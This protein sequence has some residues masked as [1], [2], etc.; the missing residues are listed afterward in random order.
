MG[1]EGDVG[2]AAEDKPGAVG[3]FLD[4]QSG[5][6][7]TVNGPTFGRTILSPGVEREDWGSGVGLG[8]KTILGSGGFEFVR[9]DGE[10]W[11]QR[12]GF[13]AKGGGEVEIGVDVMREAWSL[14]RET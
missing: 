5:F 13:C 12:L 2:G 11:R 9:S 6:D 1:G 8:G 10:E 7:E 3:L 4:L 14:K